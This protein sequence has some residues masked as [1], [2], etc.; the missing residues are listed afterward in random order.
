MVV[1]FKKEVD[2]FDRVQ[3]LSRLALGLLLGPPQLSFL[4]IR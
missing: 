4:T 2:R 1:H 3:E